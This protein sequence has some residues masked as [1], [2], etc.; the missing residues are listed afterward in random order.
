MKMKVFTLPKDDLKF[1]HIKSE[2]PCTCIFIKFS[3]YINPMGLN[4]LT[5]SLKYR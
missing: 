2:N 5:E 3:T 1:N 4:M